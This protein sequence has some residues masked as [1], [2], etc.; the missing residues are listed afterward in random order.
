MGLRIFLHSVRLV[1]GQLNGALRV[2]ALLYLISTAI[3]LIALM[4]FMPKIV[5]GET[6][7]LPWEVVI[8]SIATC[9][10]YLW[11]AVGWHRFVLM[12]EAPKSVVVPQFHGDR[13][14]AYFGRILQ[15][16]LIGALVGLVFGLAAVGMGLISPIIGM[17]GMF[18]L[19]MALMVVAYRL[20]PVF[21]A[22]AIGRPVNVGEAWA[23]TS[24][25]SGTIILLAVI[26]VIATMILDLPLQ[27]FMGMSAGVPLVIIWSSITGWI[28]LMVGVS[29]MTTLYGVYVEKRAIA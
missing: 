23:A 6:T 16:A 4:I 14:L 15:M 27:L 29:I 3:G 5:F 9:V 25:A 18:G 12:D 28:K 22:A 17:I 11:I 20:A 24:G 26:S 13:M 19:F 10:L 1:F 21:P 7:S 2:S 8:V